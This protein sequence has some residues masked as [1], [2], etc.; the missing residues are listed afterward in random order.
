MNCVDVLELLLRRFLTEQDREQ[1]KQLVRRRADLIG[2]RPKSRQKGGA[3]ENN[4]LIIEEMVVLCSFCN[5]ALALR[6]PYQL[7]SE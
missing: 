5:I 7:S 3:S 6:I 1:A 2:S 4:V